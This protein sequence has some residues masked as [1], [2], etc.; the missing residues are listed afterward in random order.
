MAKVMVVMGSASDKDKMLPAIK[1]LQEAPMVEVEVHVVSAHRT[2]EILEVLIEN[3]EAD[4][5]IAGAGMAA[6]L[7]G[8]IAA[9]TVRPVIGVP[10]SG[11]ALNGLDALM[12]MVQMPPG[13]PVATVAVDG[14]KN[15]AILALQMLGIY[16]YE[17]VA[18]V[19]KEREKMSAGVIESDRTISEEI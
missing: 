13:I 3:S 9:L 5:F 19:S 16:E 12:S 18:N 7:P 17:V 4:V 1:R 14:A 8:A 11:S 2:P 6:A 15:A 10:L